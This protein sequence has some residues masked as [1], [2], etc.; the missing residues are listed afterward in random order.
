[1]NFKKIFF[2]FKAYLPAKP[3]EEHFFLTISEVM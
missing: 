1:M 2:F 3:T